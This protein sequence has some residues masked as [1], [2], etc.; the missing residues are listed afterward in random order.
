MEKEILKNVAENYLEQYHEELDIL[1]FS[2]LGG[3]CIN[4]ALKLKTNRGLLFLKWNNS[5]PIDL[6]IREAE[7]LSEFKKSK[8]SFLVFPEPLLS[9][10]IDKSP[11]YLLT[12]FLETGRSGTDD[13]KLGRGLAQLHKVKAEQ[14]GFAHNNYCGATIQNNN[15][16]SNWVDFFTENRI[17]YLINLIKHNRTWS[18]SDEKLA[19]KFLNKVPVLLHHDVQPSLIHGDLWS[20][21]YMYTKNGPALIDPCASYCDREF[22]MGIMTMFGGFSQTVFDAYNEY[23]PLQPG[24]RDRNQIYQLYHVLN[25]YFLFGGFYKNQA[26]DIMKKY[27]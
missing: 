21:N 15:R 9:K 10:E 6:F 22:E 1:S 18:I 19:D 17:L 24:W 20:G 14:F 25:H 8:N 27:S 13:E 26:V 2:P 23:Y 3:G 4:S 7:S 12:S 11:G 5:G 16:A